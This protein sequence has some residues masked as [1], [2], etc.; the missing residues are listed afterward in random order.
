MF[1]DNGTFTFEF[2]DAAGN[3]GSA[4]AEVSTIVTNPAGTALVDIISPTD[5]SIEI[6]NST[7]VV[8]SVP[9]LPNS[10]FQVIVN[11]LTS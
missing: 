5:N 9:L 3:T 8:A 10:P 11:G 6:N 2:I 7:T 4:L 1:T